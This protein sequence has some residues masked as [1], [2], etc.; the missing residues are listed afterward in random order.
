MWSSESFEVKYNVGFGIPI[1]FPSQRKKN[2]SNKSTNK[3]IGHLWS[4]NDLK[5]NIISDLDSHQ[6][7]KSKKKILLKSVQ[8]QRNYALIKNAKIVMFKMDLRTFQY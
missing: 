7:Y 3:E 5:E 8:K 2:Y 4:E 6:I 1:E